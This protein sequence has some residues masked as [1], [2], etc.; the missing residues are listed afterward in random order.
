MVMHAL[1]F[2]SKLVSGTA[3]V[4]AAFAV[5]GGTAYIGRR[6][7]L[8]F[9]C[10]SGPNP[11]SG[12]CLG[13]P[14]WGGHDCRRV[15]HCPVQSCSVG[16]VENQRGIIRNRQSPR[17]ETQ[18]GSHARVRAN[19]LRFLKSQNAK[20]FPGPTD[21][22]LLNSMVRAHLLMIDD[23]NWSFYFDQHVLF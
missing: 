5:V 11:L 6:M 12:H 7:G 19:V 13:G 15:G 16:G 22:I 10:Q 9:L 3:R 14:R 18:E 1:S 4:G 23:P 2:I 17:T 20:R 8:E 21:S